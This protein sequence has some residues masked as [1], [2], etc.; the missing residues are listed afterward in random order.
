ME[1]TVSNVEVCNLAYTGQFDQIKQRILSDK[2]LASKTD[3]VR[4]HAPLAHYS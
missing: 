3:Q 4:E 1:G 2:L